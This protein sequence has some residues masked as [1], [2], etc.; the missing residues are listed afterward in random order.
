MFTGSEQVRAS[1]GRQAEGFW[2][3]QA[4]VL[5][6]MET[7][8]KGWF[9]RRRADATEALQAAQSMSASTGMTDAVQVYQRWLQSSFERLAADSAEAQALLLKLSG[10]WLEGAGSAAAAGAAAVDAEVKSAA[11]EAQQAAQRRSRTA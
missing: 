1:L 9:E 4:Q 5:D 2:H 10:A 7:L 3:A 8:T 11:A 6:N